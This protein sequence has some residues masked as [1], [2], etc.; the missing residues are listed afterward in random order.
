M[1]RFFSLENRAWSA[2]FLNVLAMVSQFSALCTTGRA[3]G[4]SLVMLAIFLF[5]QITFAQQA[6]QKKMWALFWGMVLSFVFTAASTIFVIYVR[7]V[8]PLRQ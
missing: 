6:Y 7:F 8:A 3:D 5:V 2:S 4:V 1:K